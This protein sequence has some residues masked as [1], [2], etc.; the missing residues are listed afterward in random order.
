MGKLGNT[1]G[2]EAVKAF[3]KADWRAIG[4]VGS[5][6]VLV[7]SETRVNLSIPQRKELSVGTPRKL[8]R[9]AGMTVDES[10]KLL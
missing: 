1:S 3:E 7:K 2:R 6:L 5:H 4:Q 9:L 8:I 10:V